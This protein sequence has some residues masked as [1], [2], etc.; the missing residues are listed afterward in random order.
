MRG[1]SRAILERARTR[2]DVIVTES[3]ARRHHVAVGDTL[4]VPT[5]GGIA[6]LAVDGVF[7]DYS[8]DAGG[9]M[10]DH[11][12]YERLWGLERVESFAL[13]LAPG[14]EASTVRRELIARAGAD[15]V[16]SVMPNQ[17]LRAQV[18]R[19]FDQTFRITGALQA[20][21]V[22]V[23]VLGLVTTLTSLIFQRTREI[24]ALRAV[25][26][27][28]GQI[29]TMVL[30]ESGLLGL[31][32]TLLGC[33]CGWLL[34]LLLVHVINRQFFGWTIRLD[35]DPLVFVRAIVL[36]LAASLVAGLFPARLAARRQPAEALRM[37]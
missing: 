22:L 33:V 34:A 10:M 11:S 3:F 9:L 19:V 12:L 7:Y 18:L 29:R 27:Q 1:D 35:L 20:I 15:R 36:M 4:P 14:A 6:R 21:A 2:G 24:G 8:T 16:L 37:E 17:S 28:R 26:A 31:T 23:A 25:G 30:V 32:G 13:Y 5:P